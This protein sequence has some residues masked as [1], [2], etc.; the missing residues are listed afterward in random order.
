[1][2]EPIHIGTIYASYKSSAPSHGWETLAP[3]EWEGSKVGSHWPFG[4]MD[5]KFN[6][7]SSEE[8]QLG[9]PRCTL[10]QARR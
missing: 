7:I 8:M 4:F 1:M 10:T 9:P 3:H 2:H 5:F 6:F